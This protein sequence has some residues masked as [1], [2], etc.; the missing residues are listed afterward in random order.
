MS[1]PSEQPREEAHCITC[2]D[3][4]IVMRVLAR[5]GTGARC[6]SADGVQADVALDLVSPVA[7]GEK[8]LVH[9]GVAIR[10]LD[11]SP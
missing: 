9:A 11:T 7:P 3:E 5:D 10:R 8:I 4:G 2:A 6:E 1:E